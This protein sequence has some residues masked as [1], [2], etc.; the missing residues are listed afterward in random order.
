M[1]GD[2]SHLSSTKRERP[3]WSR[4][5]SKSIVTSLVFS[6]LTHAEQAGGHGYQI[7]GRHIRL[8][9][10]ADDA[11]VFAEH[12]NQLQKPTRAIAI[13][14]AAIGVRLNAA[15]SCLARSPEAALTDAGRRGRAS[16]RFVALDSEGTLAEQHMTS[17]TPEEAARYLGVWFSFCGPRG[18]AHGR[19]TTQVSKLHGTIKLF[20][21]TCAGLSP[22]FSQLSEVIGNT[23]CRRLIF[24]VQG[25]VPIWGVFTEARCL[26]ARW[27]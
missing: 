24:P 13:A 2:D 22:S 5:R 16:M 3:D 7:H 1:C 27:V 26:A 20:F 17:V 25:R 21:K 19:W 6:A 23:L 9:C 8:L 11:A 18:G 14:L 10:Y 4:S 15:K 12:W